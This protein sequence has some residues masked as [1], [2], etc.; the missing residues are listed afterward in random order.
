MESESIIIKPERSEGSLLGQ[1][2]ISEHLRR[3]GYP[4]TSILSMLRCGESTGFFMTAQCACSA[5][6]FVAKWNCNL[7]VCPSCAEKRKRRLRRKY[8]PF[9]D[10]FPGDRFNH[11]YRHLIISPRNYG[12]YDYGLKKVRENLKKFMRSKY[13]QKRLKG[14]MYNIETKFS[15]EKGWNVHV[16][17]LTYG[18]FLDNK[19][20]P[21]HKD[22]K[23][24]RL[25]KSCSGN[26]DVNI[27]IVKK[28]NSRA[29]ALNYLLKYITQD[30][31]EDF[32]K[33]DTNYIQIAEY[34]YSSRKKRLITTT[35][36]FYNFKVLPYPIVCTEC[37]GRVDFICD[38]TLSAEIELNRRRPPDP[39]DL[40][41]F[42]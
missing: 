2:A 27:Y 21:G 26:E 22:S 7:R 24:V 10:A 30:A 3:L 32:G 19:V 34:I 8:M 12:S 42:F 38:G 11:A 31:K 20:R 39:P 29:Y 13:I 9:L 36:V 18:R 1:T 14:S 4:E 25:W 6:S 40:Y 28:F 35:G 33:H 5:H 23:L 15:P 41:D 17:M 37:G 16:H